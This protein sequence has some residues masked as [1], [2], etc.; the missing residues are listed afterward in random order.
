MTRRKFDD[1]HTHTHTHTHFFLSVPE[2]ETKCLGKCLVTQQVDSAYG[3][4]ILLSRVCPLQYFCKVSIFGS[5]P[6]RLRRMRRQY[7]EYD[8]FSAPHK[9]NT[10]TLIWIEEKQDEV[11]L[12]IRMVFTARYELNL[13]TVQVILFFL[14]SCHCTLLT[15]P[16]RFKFTKINP[17]A[18]KWRYGN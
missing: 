17:L 12:P 10:K 18:L 1:T 11:L 7:A 9:E 16:C 8:G 15:Q 13:Y 2:R 3:K 4:R 14:T 5:V 6:S